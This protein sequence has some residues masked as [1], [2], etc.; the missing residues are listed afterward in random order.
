M[1][2]EYLNLSKNKIDDAGLEYL[3]NL[4]YLKELVILEMRL[5]DKCFLVLDNFN[6]FSTINIIE[7]DK[8]NLILKHIYKNFNGFRLKSLSSIKFVI[9]QNNLEVLFSLNNICPS[10]KIL[11]L[12]NTNLSDHG[13]ARLK[14]NIS[15]M[16]NI[17]IINLENTKLTIDSKKYFKYFNN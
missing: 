5:S 6:Y 12:S 9:I 4:S 15:K 10:L 8:T 11:D 7:C 3:K 2:L 16:K 14:L 1:F 17:E 13:L